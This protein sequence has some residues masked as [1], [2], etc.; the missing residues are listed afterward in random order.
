MIRGSLAPN[1]LHASMLATGGNGMAFIY[2]PSDGAFSTRISG[3]AN[4][5]PMWV[6]VS[7]RGSTITASQSVNGST[8][9]NVGS[10]TLSLPTSFY[11]GLAVSSHDSNARVTASFDN[12]AVQAPSANQP[13][14]VSLTA[15]NNG[16]T[17][18]APANITISA[19]AG[20][21]DGTVSRVDFYQGSTLIATDTSSPYSITWSSVPAGTYSLTA[22]ATDNGGTTTTS[23]A[24]SV[25]VT[26]GA[27][28]PPTVSL[29]APNNGATFTA[30]ANITVSATASDTDGTIARVEF[31][32]GSTL[33]AADTTS[34]YSVTWSNVPAGTYSLTARATDDDGGTATSAAHSITVNAPTNQP[35][36]V[37]LTAPNTGATFT[38]PANITVSANAGDTD[39]TVS[40]VDFFQGSTLIGTDTTSPYSITWSNVP[41]GTY[42]LTAHATDNAGATTTSAARTIT[43]TALPSGWTAGDIGSPAMAGSTQYTSGTFSITGGGTDIWGT[44]DQFHFAYHQFTGDVDVVAR[45]AT[46]GQT[47]AWSKAGVMIRASL[48]ANAAHASMFATPGNGMAFQ[49][50]PTTGGM[51]STSPGSFTQ[52]PRW[53][54]LSL[55]GTTITASESPDGTT[56]TQVGTQALSLTPPFYVGL[57]VTSHDAA[58]T[59]NASFDNVL[60][61]APSANQPPTVSLT[62][63]N[64]GATFT[65]PANITVSAN[66]GDT[67]GTVSRVD[68]FQGST[69]I[70]TDTTSPYSI[71]WSN[72]PAGTYSLTARATDNGGTTTTSAARSIT[73]TGS[74]NPPPSVSL[75]AP[76]DGATF[77]APA[78]ITISANASDTNGTI[79]QVEFYHGSTLIATDTTSPY[80]VTWSNVPAGTYSLTARATDN[81]GATT[82]SAARSVTVNAVST[83]RNAVFNPSPDHNTLVTSYLFEVFAAGADTRT[84]TPIRS[85]NLG[86]PAP[87]NGE[88]TADVTATINALAPGNYQATVAAVASG[89]SSRSGPVTFTR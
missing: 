87:V 14:T 54:K 30:P 66:A 49:R 31:Y 40:R 60:V 9:T 88:I 69:L 44:S 26:G 23:A 70:G 5:A 46:L 21:P 59:V 63:P 82:T 43:V 84:A 83:Q 57:A 78:N 1:S 72:V 20:D 16:A 18:T 13:P 7:R 52:A 33:I 64:N 67:D 85:Q 50:R 35:P 11:V 79:A 68:F 36:G 77:T 8:W 75:T 22:R 61:Q 37:A 28:Q 55:R 62:A 76:A 56:W 86:K 27:N 65:A 47:H 24:R 32:Q 34:P 6:K 74:T 10:V 42:S 39:G 12:V 41:A 25:T 38:A 81:G 71:T 89:G 3:T 15:P 2:R 45:V 17:F 4:S 73:V 29:T 80:S 51:S 53:V 48:A 19:D 58:A